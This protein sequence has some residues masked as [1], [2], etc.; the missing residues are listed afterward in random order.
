[1]PPGRRS[2]RRRTPRPSPVPPPRPSMPAQQRMTCAE[3]ASY[4]G[5]VDGRDDPPGG[6]RGQPQRRAR[7]D[8]E[9]AGLEGG[10]R[11][12]RPL[13]RLAAAADDQGQ[14]GQL[15]MAQHVDRRDELPEVDMQHPGGEHGGIVS[16][17][18]QRVDPGAWP[19]PAGD[20]GD[21]AE[22]RAP[23]SATMSRRCLRCGLGQ[24]DDLAV[25][26]RL[27]HAALSGRSRWREVYW[28]TTSVD[29]RHRP[30]SERSAHRDTA[31]KPWAP[32]RRTATR[33][34]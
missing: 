11:H 5:G 14:A 12:D 21:P 33:C 10:R 8:A 2:V 15:W 7:A 13:S 19:L 16:R 27:N 22:G 25:V 17:L 1:M 30:R 4:T 29:G 9:R 6:L 23:D 32:A 3:A 34:L 20:R 24:T 28:I 26:K 18:W 31:M